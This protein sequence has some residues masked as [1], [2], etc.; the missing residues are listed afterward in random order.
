MN[1]RQVRRII[2]QNHVDAYDLMVS[3]WQALDKDFA[4][5]MGDAMHDEGCPA[6]MELMDF[7]DEYA[8]V[9]YPLAS[10]IK[11]FTRTAHEVLENPDDAGFNKIIALSDMCI[12]LGQDLDAVFLNGLKELKPYAQTYDLSEIANAIKQIREFILIMNDGFVKTRNG[13][14]AVRNGE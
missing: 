3:T 6:T 11:C 14:N 7:F 1:S 12:E 4:Q 10:N 9:A 2:Q 8:E 5:A 13:I